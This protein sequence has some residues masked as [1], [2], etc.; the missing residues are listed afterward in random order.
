MSFPMN[1]AGAGFILFSTDMRVLLVQDAKTH[2]W[3][4]PKGHR[5]QEDESDLAT[6][7]RELLEETGIPDSAYAIVQTPFRITRGSSSYIFRYATMK[8]GAYMGSVQNRKEI[9]TMRWIPLY[10]LLQAEEFATGGNKY[11]RTWI[12]DVRSVANK[13]FVQVLNEHLV[14][15][16]L[17]VLFHS[18][19]GPNST[20]NPILS[21]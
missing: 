18:V 15:K 5:E 2:K 13:K 12:E 7:Q 20:T 10:D 1:Y 21:V 11:L 16:C 4:F 19:N 14:A 8:Q 6:A 3:G 9:R 17:S